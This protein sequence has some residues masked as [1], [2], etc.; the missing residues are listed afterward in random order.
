MN[1]PLGEYGGEVT[2]K[3]TLFG[4]TYKVGAILSSEVLGEVSLRHRRALAGAGLVKY[5]SEPE[6]TVATVSAKS[7]DVKT[8][9]KAKQTPTKRAA[10]KTVKKKASRSTKKRKKK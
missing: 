9:E 1:E 4:E 8:T 5:Y 3:V 6:G 7:P 2:R 10:K